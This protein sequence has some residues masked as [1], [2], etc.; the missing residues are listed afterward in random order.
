MGQ[1][2]LEADHLMILYL[3][4]TKREPVPWKVKASSLHAWG[5]LRIIEVQ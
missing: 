4:L 3:R 1:T 2:G 5:C